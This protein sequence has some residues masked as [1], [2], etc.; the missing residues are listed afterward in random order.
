MTL[1]QTPP[2]SPDS[3]DKYTSQIMT[4]VSS[5]IAFFSNLPIGK[6]TRSPRRQGGIS[7]GFPGCFPQS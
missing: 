4:G 5:I 7:A 6:P 2:D 1:A 3:H